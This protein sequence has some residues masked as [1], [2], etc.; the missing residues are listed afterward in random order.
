MKILKWTAIVILFLFVVLLV[1]GAIAPKNIVMTASKTIAAPDSV[2]FKQVNNLRNWEKWSP[3]IE[4]DS[5]MEN[6]YH[7]P[8]A[9]V[10]SQ[11]LWH[12]KVQGDGMMIITRSDSNKRI[13]FA[14]DFMK[15]GTATS[16]WTFASKG[17]SVM[18]TWSTTINGL[19]YPMGRIMGLLMNRMMQNY[20]DRGFT[21]L[22]VA[23]QEEMTLTKQK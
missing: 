21:N 7:G 15:Q 10:G 1:I 20:Y 6:Q 23:S 16:E 11:M 19:S 8:D 22:E 12:S 3:F 17:D 4:S 5:T 9:G 14:L 2:V 13:L 18:V